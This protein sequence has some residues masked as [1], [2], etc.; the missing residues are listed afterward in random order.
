MRLIFLD[1]D[2]RFLYVSQNLTGED[3]QEVP[4]R[5]LLLRDAHSRIPASP[6][7]DIGAVIFVNLIGFADSGEESQ[8]L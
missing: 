2:L 3:G 4:L 8:T 7:G 6:L 1:F 5:P